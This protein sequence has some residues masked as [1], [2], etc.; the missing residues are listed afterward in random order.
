[1]SKANDNYLKVLIVD[2]MIDENN[3]FHQKIT[4]DFFFFR[5]F[6]EKSFKHAEGMALKKVFNYKLEKRKPKI[7]VWKKEGFG[8][9]YAEIGT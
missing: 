1:M 2:S 6:N 9:E 7:S 5:S 8:K 3:V 4:H